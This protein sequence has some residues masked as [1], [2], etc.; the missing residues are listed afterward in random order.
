M[1]RKFTREKNPKPTPNC[2]QTEAGWRPLAKRGVM[3]LHFQEEEASITKGITAACLAMQK[4]ISNA[5]RTCSRPISRSRQSWRRV[6]QTWNSDAMQLG[7]VVRS[8]SC[9]LFLSLFGL[10]LSSHSAGSSNKLFTKR[11]ETNSPSKS[12]KTT[13]WDSAEVEVLGE[14]WMSLISV[15]FSRQKDFAKFEVAH[16]IGMFPS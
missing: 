8:S 7:F 12:C 6:L 16:S 5:L 2:G 3:T 9:F 14:L 13:S 4:S 11:S 10:Q 1:R 15:I